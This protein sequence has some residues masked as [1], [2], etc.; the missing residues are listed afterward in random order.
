VD[1][2]HGTAYSPGFT[3]AGLKTVRAAT[4]MRPVVRACCGDFSGVGEYYERGPFDEQAEPTDGDFRGHPY[5][6]NEQEAP[7][8][9]HGMQ[10]VRS[11]AGGARPPDPDEPPKVLPSLP[12][13]DDAD[14]DVIEGLEFRDAFP[15]TDASTALTLSLR[16]RRR[17]LPEQVGKFL[18]DTLGSI[19]RATAVGYFE[20]SGSSSRE[21]RGGRTIPIDVSFAIG[22]KGDPRRAVELIR[23]TLWWVGAPAKTDLD[24]FPL[25]IR[26]APD[27]SASRF[28]QLAALTVTRWKQFGKPGHRIDRMPFSAAQRQAVRRVLDEA[29]A[30]EAADG[31]E[32]VATA[33]GGRVSVATKYL[34]DAD[35]F[36]TLNLLADVLTPEASGL[37]YRLMR[38]GA[39]MLLPM[40][41]AASREVARTLDCDWPKVRAAA[42]AEALHRV[43]VRGP[44]AWWRRAGKGRG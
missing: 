21:G 37:V 2:Y 36:H 8:G 1:E 24:G 11:P 40:G 6:L 7:A 22:L 35:D 38:E 23:E 39:L 41:L 17:P 10:Q 25:A 32:A 44:Y 13:P 30:V 28:L 20:T 5:A 16:S 29:G 19:F 18:S 27:R 26:R 42:S 9:R 34:G 15:P 33:D 14:G 4:G 12:E 43:L 3:K 31:W